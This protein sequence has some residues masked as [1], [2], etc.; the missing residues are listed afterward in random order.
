MLAPSIELVTE[1]NFTPESNSSIFSEL[2]PEVLCLD[3]T[4]E[5]I[6]LLAIIHC[7]N[8]HISNVLGKPGVVCPLS[9]VS[10]SHFS[11]N[12][13]QLITNHCLRHGHTLSMVP[14]SIVHLEGSQTTYYVS[15]HYLESVTMLYE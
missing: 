1:N 10:T 11:K 6:V 13:H 3:D 9:F 8:K 2:L 5:R 14:G 15:L 4:E 7:T 12:W